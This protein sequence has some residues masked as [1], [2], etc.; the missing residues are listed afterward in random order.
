MITQKELNISNRSYINKDFYQIYPEILELVGKI[1]ERWHPE[2]SNESDPG[3]V[4]LKLLA[5]IADKNNYNIDKN[6]L[7]C[8][9]PSATQEESMRKLCDMMGYQM[10][11]S[12]SA[13]TELSF[14]WL[15][16]ISNTASEGYKESSFKFTLPR[17]KTTVQ[18]SES[19]VTY[20]L[21]QN[22]S[23]TADNLNKKKTVRA[24]EGEVIELLVGNTNVITLQNLDNLNRLYLPES[25]VAENGIFIEYIT[26]GKPGEWKK[27]DNLNLYLPGE[28]V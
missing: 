25:Q 1:T 10:K 9:M 22:I 5:F 23:F 26:N 21:T 4:L 14:T 7:E 19:D 6:I 20:T 11:Y 2:S 27:V 17:Y 15:G 3:V 13:E 12:K 16:N 8:F 18:N 24:I 28:C